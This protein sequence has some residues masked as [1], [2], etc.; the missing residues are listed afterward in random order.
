MKENKDSRHQ[1]KMQSCVTDIKH[2]E[3]EDGDGDGDDD[4]EQHNEATATGG[5]LLSKGNGKDENDDASDE[6]N[7]D[8][9]DVDDRNGNGDGNKIGAED[10]HKFCFKNLYDF[11][12]LLQ[13][14]EKSGKL[15]A[16]PELSSPSIYRIAQHYWIVVGRNLT[17]DLLL[18]LL[19]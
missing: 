15:D 19:L 10:E 2:P 3:G 14:S 4:N 17:C 5:H 18:L 16:L 1:T 7:D 6:N 8:E 9:D 12:R 13:S 11:G